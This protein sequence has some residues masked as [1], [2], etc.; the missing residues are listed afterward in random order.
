[1]TFEELQTAWQATDAKLRDTQ[2]LQ[3]QLVQTLVQQRSCGRL[4]AL[5]R[6]FTV[7]ALLLLLLTPL[8]LWGIINWNP[9]GLQTWYGFAPL[10]LW[11]CFF[12]AAGLL[13]WRERQRVARLTLATADLRAAL[14]S[15]I[16][17]QQHYL[18]MLGGLGWLAVMLVF[19]TNAARATEHLAEMSRLEALAAYGSNLLF[20]G[21]Y[22]RLFWRKQLP[23]VNRN[24][25]AELQ[26]WLTELDELAPA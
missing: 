9:F 21:L 5:Q 12:A 16:G 11:A 15:V 7:Q 2:H 25:S 13:T 19:V 14:T 17:A 10:L 23:G 22:S 6:R 20:A 4:A 3:Q 24:N 18:K 1:M 8:L 26:A